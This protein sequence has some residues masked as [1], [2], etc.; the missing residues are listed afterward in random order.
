MHLNNQRTAPSG[1]IPLRVFGTGTLNP[2]ELWECRAPEGPLSD[3]R[4]AL[5]SFL[6]WDLTGLEEDDLR[7]AAAAAAAT[8]GKLDDVQEARTFV[9]TRREVLPSRPLPPFSAF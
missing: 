4:W 8:G 9:A 6:T 3:L 2:A 7:G 1:H 5:K